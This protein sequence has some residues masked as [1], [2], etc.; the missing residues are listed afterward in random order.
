MMRNDAANA[1]HWPSAKIHDTMIGS[2]IVVLNIA[3]SKPRTRCIVDL[4][5]TS[6]IGLT[7]VCGPGNSKVE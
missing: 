6:G 4:A 2:S 7:A 1:S 5:R 3:S